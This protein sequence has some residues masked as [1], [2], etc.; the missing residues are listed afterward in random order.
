MNPV[1]YHYFNQFTQIID[2]TEYLRLEH[3]SEST[4]LIKKSNN[5]VLLEDDFYGN[6]TCGLIDKNNKWAIVGGTHLRLWTVDFEQYYQTEVFKNIHLIR[7]KNSK[8]IEIL[9]DPWDEIAA[10]WELNLESREL[11]KIKNFRK[12]Y[13]KPYCENIEW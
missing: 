10:I 7:I 12:Y 1:K 4:F 11:I 13:G 6:P 3:E 9:I 5:E 8:I 2:E